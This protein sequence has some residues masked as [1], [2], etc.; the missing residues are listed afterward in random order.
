MPGAPPFLTSCP[1]DCTW[2]AIGPWP[3]IMS[4]RPEEEQIKFE[5]AGAA[6]RI[7]FTLPAFAAHSLERR[8]RDES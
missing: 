1:G 2:K 4:F 8:I 7:A 3:G 6:V 5:C